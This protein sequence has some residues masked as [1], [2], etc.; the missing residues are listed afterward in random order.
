MLQGGF[1]LLDADSGAV[2]RVFE[3]QYNPTALRRILG[4]PDTT[5]PSDTSPQDR[6][7]A[8]WAETIMLELELDAADA[9]TGE[10]SAASEHGIAPRL[11]ALESIAAPET[12][13]SAPLAVFVWGRIRILPVQVVRL[14]ILEEAFD[15]SLNPVRATVAMTMSVLREADLGEQGKRL[16]QAYAEKKE[17]LASLTQGSLSVLGATDILG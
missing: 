13:V 16:Y 12:I 17:R 7:R 1:V 6:P 4:G 5:T 14:D 15:A 8:Q 3:F 10:E 11:A 2:V 9:A